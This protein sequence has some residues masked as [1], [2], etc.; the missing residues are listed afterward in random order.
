MAPIISTE[1]LFHTG[2]H[3]HKDYHEIETDPESIFF[4]MGGNWNGF[5]VANIFTSTG[6]YLSCNRKIL[7]SPIF[8]SPY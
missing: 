5:I 8:C 7:S 1:A 6:L 3:V 2:S 4:F